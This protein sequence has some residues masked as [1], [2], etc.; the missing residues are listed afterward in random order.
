MTNYFWIHQSIFKL[1][2]RQPTFWTNL[3]F[4]FYISI[5]YGIRAILPCYYPFIDFTICAEVF[6]CSWWDPEN[7]LSIFDTGTQRLTTLFQVNFESKPHLL[8]Y[9]HDSQVPYVL[10]GLI[11]TKW[12]KLSTHYTYRVTAQTSIIQKRIRIYTKHVIQSHTV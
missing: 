6:Y 8:R 11:C 7:I 1:D 3:T 5:P 12:N 4:D 2:F 10:S 9:Q